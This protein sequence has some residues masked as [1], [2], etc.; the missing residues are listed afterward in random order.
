MGIREKITEGPRKQGTHA[1][2]QEI[3]LFLSA[4]LVGVPALRLR[5]LYLAVSTLAFAQAVSSVLLNPDALGRFLPA[6]L[7]RAGLGAAVL[8]AGIF[9]AWTGDLSQAL[10]GRPLP[11][12]PPLGKP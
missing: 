7:R 10:A 4:D 12:L 5:G 3:R 11:P 8:L 1:A 9:L 6:S 2:P